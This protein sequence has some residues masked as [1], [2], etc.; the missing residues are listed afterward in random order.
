MFSAF[1]FSFTFLVG[2][3]VT[4]AVQNLLEVRVL[5]FCGNFKAFVV[6]G[7]VLGSERFFLF[8]DLVSGG[9]SPSASAENMQVPY[10]E[11]P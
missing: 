3:R 4:A 5:I 1:A 8:H 11:F 7:E 6:L 9:L 10:H 2:V